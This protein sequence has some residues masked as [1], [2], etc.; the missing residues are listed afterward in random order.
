VGNLS[1]Q[2]G[3]LVTEFEKWYL[4]HNVQQKDLDKYGNPRGYFYTATRLLFEQYQELAALKVERD[5]LAALIVAIN[6]EWEVDQ[7]PEYVLEGV[8]TL[9]ES[10]PAHNAKVIDVMRAQGMEFSIERY[11]VDDW[12]IF[13]EEFDAYANTLRKQAKE[14]GHDT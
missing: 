10:A 11:P 3:D 2:I 14:Q 9:L 1:I 13:T 4:S 8:G 5:E 6:R 7:Y 12:V